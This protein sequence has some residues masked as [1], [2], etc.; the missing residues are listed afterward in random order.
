M[1]E[2]YKTARGV[3]AYL[4]P[5]DE[6]S[7]PAVW[8]AER[9]S[10]GMDQ[11][12]IIPGRLLRILKLPTEAYLSLVGLPAP[13]DPAWRALVIFT[14]R[15]YFR[16]IWVLQELVL[17]KPRVLAICGDRTFEIDWL[18]RACMWLRELKEKG[19]MLLGNGRRPY[20]MNLLTIVP[21]LDYST[22]PAELYNLFGRTRHLRS[23]D[24]RDKVIALL[25]LADREDQTIQPD[26]EQPV[27][28]FYRDVAGTMLTKGKCLR[29]LGLVEDRSQTQI[30]GLP[31]W[32]PDFSVT[33]GL[34]ALGLDTLYKACSESSCHAQWS[35]GSDLLVLNASFVDEVG[36]VSELYAHY[37]T[38]FLDS[39]SSWFKTMAVYFGISPEY[40]VQDLVDAQNSPRAD[41]YQ[42]FWRT[43]IRDEADQKHPA[44]AVWKQHFASTFCYFLDSEKHIQ[45]SSVNIPSYWPQEPDDNGIYHCSG[46]PDGV[47]GLFLGSFASNASSR[48]FFVTKTG[49]MGL[50]LIS[51]KVSDKVAVI[52]GA[53]ELCLLRK[54]SGDDFTFVGA[55]YV[56]GLMHGESLQSE[57]FRGFEEVGLV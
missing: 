33:V 43:I 54:N 32:V 12:K 45:G 52:S 3:Y 35:N 22:E 8:L 53:P 57:A 25:S 7:T 51:T 15:E 2:I 20:E 36:V 1:A 13:E 4:G 14:G 30:E 18:Y 47:R 55:A 29:M 56:H 48:R 6:Y 46:P 24:P 23:S 37:E 26:Y 5:E 10:N 11:W 42:I 9:I 39:F 27:R 38:N 40:W 50:G 16:R 41:L 19:G 28:D 31:S 34:G 49:A 44:P 21:Y 17:A